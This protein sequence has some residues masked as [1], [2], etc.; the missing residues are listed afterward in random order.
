MIY[1]QDIDG[2]RAMAIIAV[3]LYHAFPKVFPGGFLGV[4]IFFVL[5]GYLV[6]GKLCDSHFNLKQF[7]IRRIQR[8][9]PSLVL[10]LATFMTLGYFFLYAN[11]YQSLNRHV[12]ASLLFSNHWLL[13]HEM[14]YF[15]SLADFKPLLQLWSLSIEEQFYLF[16]PLM[17]FLF[18]KKKWPLK[19]GVGCLLVISL[20]FNV[21]LNFQGV[22]T[23]YLPS[24]RLWEF[25]LGGLLVSNNRFKKDFSG[26]VFILFI[27]AL[28]FLNSVQYRL[29]MNLLV[30]VGT[31]LLIIHP[32]WVNRHILQR[33]GM[34]YLG[35]IS[36]PLYLW[37]WSLLSFFRIIY[38]GAIGLGLTMGLIVLSVF[39]SVLTYK[40]VETPIRRSVS[41]TKIVFFCLFLLLVLGLMASII[42]MRQGLIFRPINLERQILLDDLQHFDDYKKKFT[43]CHIDGVDLCLK[44]DRKNPSYVVWGDSHA[45]HLFPGLVS[46]LPHKSG[47]LISTHSCPPLLGV[48]A[49]WQG[50]VDSCLQTNQHIFQALKK[51]S[52]VKVV[53]LSAVGLFYISNTMSSDQMIDAFSPAYFHLQLAHDAGEDKSEVFL[54]GM[55]QSINALQ[56]LGKKVIVL[57]D[58]PLLPIMPIQCLARPLQKK[59]DFCQLPLNQVQKIQSSYHQLLL[60]LR[61]KNPKILFYSSL[62]GL[63]HDNQCPI[64]ENGHFLYRDSQHLSLAASEQLAKGFLANFPSLQDTY[65]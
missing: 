60:K 38:A 25:C 6:I 27:V 53:I 26:V 56:K 59:Q 63:C 58:N 29:L 7:Y 33:P 11:E 8:I 47:M 18:Y 61:L 42:D 43:K 1:R 65:F 50:D 4:D 44:N 22:D 9:L 55:Q 51:L 49:F 57:E 10:L 23:Y 32:G 54:H 64:I 35:L 17:T 37:H 36:Y 5:S 13:I 16:L 40:W 31:S 24:C 20:I 2:M 48:Q 34:I 12:M 45:E 30:C 14:G 21:T 41:Q 28:C 52:S 46:Q 3:I 39:L 15:D 19:V 62:D